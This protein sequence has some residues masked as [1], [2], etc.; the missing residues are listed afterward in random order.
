M[1]NPVTQELFREDGY[2]QEIEAIV[3]A[4]RDNAIVVDQTVFYAAG[5]GQPGDSGTCITS[6]GDTLNIIDTYKDR[7]NGDYLHILEEG[8]KV[9]AIGKPVTL[10]LDWQRRH[11]L[12]RMHS[13]M[14]M[15]CAVIPAPVTGGSIQEGRGRLDF[16]LPDTVDK[17]HITAELN[18][19][20]EKNVPMSISWITDQELDDNPSL[21][22]T[23]SVAPPRGSGKIRLIN[24]EGVD[25]Q[26]CGG[27]HVASSGEIGPVRVQ[28]VEKKGKMNRRVIVVFD[29]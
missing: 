4:T 15:L 3:T 28:K 26:P 7:D 18:K 25:F 2:L 17:E 27:T 16:D 12:M 1:D 13:A 19:L 9:P 29:E 23:M 21:V 8:A 5:G 22:R 24:F 20:I 11:R 6:A 14:H 10:K